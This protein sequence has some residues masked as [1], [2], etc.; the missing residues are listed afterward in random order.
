MKTQH[1]FVFIAFVFLFGCKNISQDEFDFEHSRH[2]FLETENYGTLNLRVY[3]QSYRPHHNDTDPNRILEI[4]NA[5]L[6]LA[7]EEWGAYEPRAIQHL[8]NITIFVANDD[9]SLWT[10]ICDDEFGDLRRVYACTLPHGW[11]LDHVGFSDPARA[12]QFAVMRYIWT[13]PWV[14]D[15]IWAHELMHNI[16]Y[17]VHGDLDHDHNFP[18]AWEMVDEVAA[19][20]R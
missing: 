15:Y 2:V 18:G 14:N 20:F 9:S 5:T 6:L 19:S 4:I 10:D 13:Q 12:T 11:L 7:E 17:F 1:L 3:E 16:L 8:S